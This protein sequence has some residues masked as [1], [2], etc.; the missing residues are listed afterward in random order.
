MRAAL[1]AAA[2]LLLAGCELTVNVVVD[3]T[4][5]A[6]VVLVPEAPGIPAPRDTAPPA[7]GITSPGRQPA[8]PAP[9]IG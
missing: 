6:T 7:P 8:P 4:A 9:G 3:D 5:P 2:V 1:L